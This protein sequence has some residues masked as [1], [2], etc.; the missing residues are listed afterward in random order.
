MTPILS[1]IVIC[2]LCTYYI[3]AKG[4]NTKNDSLMGLKIFCYFYLRSLN[5][6]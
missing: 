6:D 3:R 4:D 1:K 5:K 2:G